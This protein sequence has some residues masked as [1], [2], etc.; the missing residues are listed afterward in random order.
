MKKAACTA[1]MKR[2]L[3]YVLISFIIWINGNWSVSFCWIAKDHERY[4]TY[5]KKKNQQFIKWG[6]IIYWVL[7]F[8]V[9]DRKWKQY[10]RMKTRI[11]CYITVCTVVIKSMLCI[12]GYLHGYKDGI[13]RI[14][15]Q[16][17][18]KCTKPYQI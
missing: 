14:Q 2:F 16:C 6:F 12:L 10:P 4:K 17:A 18:T 13:V 7:Q 9:R 11:C 8:E 5:L 3:F 1:K 15:I